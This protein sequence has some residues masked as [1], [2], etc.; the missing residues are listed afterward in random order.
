[1]MTNLNILRNHSWILFSPPPKV[2]ADDN[3]CGNDDGARKSAG[4]CVCLIW[5]RENF[6]WRKKDAIP[7]CKYL[8]RF[9][10]R[11]R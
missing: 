6:A 4:Q 3:K 2:H 5:T 8:W 9:P 10:D 11:A 7:V 1:M